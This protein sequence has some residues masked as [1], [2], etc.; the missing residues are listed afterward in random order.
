MLTR[1]LYSLRHLKRHCLVILM[2]CHAFSRKVLL[3]IE[4]R[5]KKREERRRGEKERRG[6]KREERRN[7]E[8]RAHTRST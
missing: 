2:S 4:E 7:E 6:E 1:L 3:W 5:R 8:S